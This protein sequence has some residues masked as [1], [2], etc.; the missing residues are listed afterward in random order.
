MMRGFSNYLTDV[1]VLS[2]SAG[3]VVCGLLL[4]WIMNQKKER[5]FKVFPQFSCDEESFSDFGVSE[6]KLV[7]VV[8]NGLKMGKGKIAAQC[9]HASVLAY[10][11]AAVHTPDTLRKWEMSGQMKVVVKVDDEAALHE[12]ID[13][14]HKVGLLTS[15]VRDAGR[16]QIPSGSKTVLGIGPGRKDLV[17]TVSG[18]LKLL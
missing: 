5:R 15:L 11:Q 17:D 1:T 12:L 2:I 9:S 8:N 7:L 4:G 18:H 6:Y 16:T 14:A 10:R 3:S 13:R